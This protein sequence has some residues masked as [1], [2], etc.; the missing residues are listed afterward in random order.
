MCGV[1][2][3]TP[4]GGADPAGALAG[5]RHYRHYFLPLTS[6]LA[7]AA[8]CTYGSLTAKRPHE[9]QAKGIKLVIFA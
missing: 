2:V 4:L 1:A 7:V 3:A 9:A 6:S 8:A 5:S